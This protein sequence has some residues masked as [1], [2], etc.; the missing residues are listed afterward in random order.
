MD[1]ERRQRAFAA[2]T[3]RLHAAMALVAQGDASAVKA[4][5]AHAEEATSFYGWGGF[6][7]GWEAVSNRWDWAEQQFR[8]GTVSYVNLTRVVT[9]D[10]AYTTDMETFRACIAG[11]D[12]PVAWTNRVTHIFR[13][14]DGEW[15]LLHRHANRLEAQVAP[16][17]RSAPNDRR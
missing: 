13:F 8:G 14:E 12:Q 2:A 17:D 16:A 9:S 6:E 4:L 5:Y 11:M 3:A 1:I 10:L 7:K 15:R